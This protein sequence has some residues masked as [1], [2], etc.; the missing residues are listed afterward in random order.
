MAASA[1]L[2]GG[3]A[4][5]GGAEERA[6]EPGRGLTAPLPAADEDRPSESGI[7]TSRSATRSPAPARPPDTSAADAWAPEAPDIG[8]AVLHPGSGGGA[9]VELQHRLRQL[10][11]Y[12]G[13][14]D[15]RYDPAVRDAV[16]H[17]QWQ[18]G[19]QGDPEGV[20]GPRTRVSLEYR[21]H[22]S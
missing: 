15:G 21:T 19:V 9:V 12:F 5:F 11:L 17:Y 10:G 18:Y 22:S 3:D 13:A 4:L 2:A 7:P 6:T 1:A 20:Y 8:P 14:D 16:T